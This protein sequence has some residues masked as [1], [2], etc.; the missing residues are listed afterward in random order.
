MDMKQL[1]ILALQVSILAMVFS[2]GLKTGVHDLLYLTRRPGLLVRSVLA[3]FVV[4]PI[5]AVLLAR[6]FNYPHTVEVALVA[7]AISP[8]PPLLPRKETKAGGYSPYALGLMAVLAL[9][10]IVV[11]PIAIVIL[12]RVFGRPFVMAA[13][14]VAR[15]LVMTVLLPLAAGMAVR[16]LLPKLAASIETPVTLLAKVLLPLAA[17]VLLIVVAPAIWARV[18]DGTVIALVLFLVIG[19]AVGHVMGGPD[20]DHSLVLAL[21]TA[22][23]HPGAALTIAAANFPEE[24]FGA[25][26][27]LYLILGAIAGF[28]YLA[29]QRRRLGAAPRAA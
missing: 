6:F 9:L 15:V 5:V 14:G 25:T 4:M 7:L 24:R 20:P 11:V 1:V 2:F 19:F 12:D 22:C 10:A 13:G 8:V 21:S 3:M 27:L 16:A 28:P 23:R 26:V 29:W 18:G 17:L